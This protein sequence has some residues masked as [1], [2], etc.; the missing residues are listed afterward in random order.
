M[1]KDVRDVPAAAEE[2]VLRHKGFFDRNM[3]ICLTPDEDDKHAYF[4]AL[5]TC[6]SYLD[7]LSGFRAGRVD[8]HNHKELSAFASIYLPQ[9]V[10]SE[11]NISLLYLVFRHKLA[12]LSHPYY[13]TNT[14]DP[15]L[16][17][18]YPALA[19]KPMWIA[20]YVDEAPANVAL[21]VRATGKP[22]RISSQSWK[23]WD[24]Y[25]DH[26]MVISLPKLWDDISDATVAYVQDVKT[27][28]GLQST[29]SACMPFFFPENGS[30][31]GV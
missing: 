3:K 21:E 29:F 14:S 13:S 22:L 26:L 8:G 17:K 12:H 4:Q 9:P 5:F 30:A 19:A 1:F 6:I 10:Y 11:L 28:A 24:V 16:V 7:M 2:F 27:D 25:Y 15:A 23:Y 20:W 18:R 31:L